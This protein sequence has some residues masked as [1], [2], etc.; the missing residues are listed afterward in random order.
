MKKRYK[1]LIAVITVYILFSLYAYYAYKSSLGD[2]KTEIPAETEINWADFIWTNRTI[3][4]KYFERTAM[5]I[6][7]K[8]EGIDNNLTFQFDTGSNRTMIYENPLSS[9]YFQNEKLSEQVSQMKFPINKLAS[10]KKVFKNAKIKF[11]DYTI[12]NER[13]SVMT[14]LGRATSEESVIAGDTIHLGTI[15][16]DIFKD[17]VLIID[18]PN[19]KF[20]ITDEVPRRYKDG[21]IDIE[22]NSNG[23]PILPLKMNSNEYKIIFD[24]GSSLFP[25]I[26]TSENINK[27][28]TNPIID[29]LEINSWGKKHTVHS[30]IIT[31]TFEI[32]G[33]KFTNVE[34]YE[35][36]TGYGIDEST[37]GMTGN[38]LFW[39]STIII[40]FKNKKFGL[41]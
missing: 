25:I 17:K 22:I 38:A 10:D 3:N 5:F 15:G 14:N 19:L 31:D 21:L 27:F 7:C 12:S 36:H 33:R 9:F 41:K 32:A 37:D 24:N 4:G 18:Y 35:N 23:R 26:A 20:A 13:A 1:I 40:D 29:S 39:D 2:W 8:M 30:R 6:P 16:A 11:G 34:A 28:T